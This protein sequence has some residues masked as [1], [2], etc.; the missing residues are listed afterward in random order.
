MKDPRRK[1]LSIP[2]EFFMALAICIVLGIL[3]YY[4]ALVWRSFYD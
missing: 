3:A 1:R 4:G 2:I